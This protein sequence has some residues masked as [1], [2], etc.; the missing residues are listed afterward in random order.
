MKAIYYNIFGLGHINPTLP[1]VAALVAKGVEVIYH[2][3]PERQALV[4][5]AGA[6]FR[7]YGRDDY[8]AADFNP[9]KNFVLQTIP[10]TMGLLPFLKAEIES[11]KPDFI[12]YDSMAPWGKLLGHIFGIP[13]FCTVTTFAL[14]EHLRRE[15]FAKH[16][17][18]ADDINLQ[19]IAALKREFDLE[20]PLINALGAYNQCNFVFT[21]K[22]FNP[23]LSGMNEEHFHF[24]GSLSTP[25]HEM[26]EFPFHQLTGRKVITMAL[27]TLLP[28]EDPSVV[29]W[30]QALLRAFAGNDRYWLVL[31]VGTSKILSE[32]GP[33]PRN[34]IVREKIP[35]KEVLEHTDVFINHGGMNSINEA[36]SAGVPIVVI[37]HSKDQFVNAARVKELGLGKVIAKNEVTSAHLKTAVVDLMLS[38]GHKKRAQQMQEHFQQTIGLEGMLTVIRQQ[39]A[40]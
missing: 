15:T 25:S 21:A 11:E 35:Q 38:D 10:A 36:L 26:L 5:K 7:N 18:M 34:A 2:T 24:I 13:A 37:P 8:Q 33:L 31:A 30:Y 14:N 1:L 27:G 19:T 6:Q 29:E 3:S 4:E 20:L 9:G 32:L 12:L 28:S 40:V 22:E 16:Q 17:V 23:P 39:V